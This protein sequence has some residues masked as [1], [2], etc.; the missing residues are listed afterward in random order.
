MMAAPMPPPLEAPAFTPLPL[1]SLR[2]TGWLGRQLRLQVE[3]LSG[4]LHELWPDVRDSAWIG[5]H[6]ESWERGPYWLDGVVP[7]AAQVDAPSLRE[8][9]ARWRDELLARQHADGWLGPVRD[10]SDPAAR[11]PWP[12]FV[13]LKALAQLAESTGDARIVPAMLRACRSVGERIARRPLDGWAWARAADWVWSLYW[14][15]D[16]CGEP[17][18]LDLADLARAQGFDWR[19]HFASFPHTGRVGREQIEAERARGGR[20]FEAFYLATHGVNNAMALKAG[21]LAWRRSR[22]RAD[23]E[24][25]RVALAA[26]DRFHGQP[27]GMFS[28]DEH[29]AGRH[30]SQGTELCSV[31]E[32]MFSLEVAL[33]V[34]GDAWIGDRLEKIAWNALPAACSPDQWTHQ[35]DQQANQ[36]LCAAVDDPIWTNNGPRSN[37]FGLEPQFGCCT[38]N[39]H[40]GWPKLAAH[41]WMRA[42]D[43]GLAAMVLAPCRLEAQVAGAQVELEVDGEY[44]FGGSVAIRGH[45]D[46]EVTLPLWL[47]VPQWAEGA[48]ARVASQPGEDLSA[49]D[50]RLF[51]VALGPRGA[52]LSVELPMRPRAVSGFADSVSIERGPLVYALAIEEDWRRV[53]GE[54]PAP[55][56][57]VHPKGPWSYALD[58]APE[59]PET[60]LRFEARGV[61]AQPFSPA[62]APWVAHARGARVEG[63][64]LAH[65][66]AQAPPPSPVRASGPLEPL[67][68]L[69]YGATR[70][71]VTSLPLLGDRAG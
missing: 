17:W 70:L 5:G 55:D 57:E 32:A 71:R 29:L 54:L 20:A 53:A 65:G 52:E 59:A 3:G 18:L 28:C 37:L 46:R 44:P 25:L 36:V 49:G 58:L 45:A 64:G 19:A 1:G 13:A 33:S 15:H 24:A 2:P 27:N 7:L 9:V 26:L 4:H 14:L 51:H 66:A 12:V 8:A 38:A 22:A 68:L 61:G 63:W 67:R 50:F 60:S 39:L 16:R 10:V 31:V 42:A 40:Q 62:G 35:Y 11:D 41:L 69:P 43:G 34:L 47:R 21:A 23:R 6:G 56:W 48:S 30:P